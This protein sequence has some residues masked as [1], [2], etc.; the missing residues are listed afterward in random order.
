MKKSA[1]E[2]LAQRKFDSARKRLAASLL[3]LEKSVEQK[4]SQE[5]AESKKI[6]SIDGVDI[7]AKLAEIK[8]TNQKLE[9]ELKEI[10]RNFAEVG[11]ENL[12]LHEK[13]K[14]L[15]ERLKTFREYGERIV[16][17][18]EQNLAKIEEIIEQHD[19]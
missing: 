17:S 19:N 3:N 1:P 8:I 7:E 12:F 18:V 16:N 15:A 13:N 5:I 6:S 4:I 2:S 9:D 11:K 10:Q 14:F